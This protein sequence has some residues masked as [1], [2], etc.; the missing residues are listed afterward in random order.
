[1]KL[2][3]RILPTLWLCCVLAGCA[4][5]SP[6]TPAPNP[7]ATSLLATSTLAA[8][9]SSPTTPPADKT[10]LPPF[11]P[12][13]GLQALKDP[14]QL[15]WPNLNDQMEQFI[16]SEWQYYSCEQPPS[17]VAKAYRDQ[18][19]KAPYNL[20]ETN[21]LERDEGTLGIYFAQSGL[22]YYMWFIAQSDNAHRSYIIVAES[23]A[24]VEC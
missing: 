2:M 1:M 11:P 5:A 8:T 24:S 22:W 7:Q 14:V 10:D 17:E 16:G 20:Q 15:S 3:I 18:L 12:C 13:T 6:S 4:G 19:T 23:F 9:T 21:W